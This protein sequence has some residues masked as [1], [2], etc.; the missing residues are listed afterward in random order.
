MDELNSIGLIEGLKV[1]RIREME[2]FEK[3]ESFE[4]ERG[5]SFEEGGII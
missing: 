2:S 4:G 1:K 5:E 3:G